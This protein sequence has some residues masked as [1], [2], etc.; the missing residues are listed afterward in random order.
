MHWD[1]EKLRDNRDLALK[2]SHLTGHRRDIGRL[3][4]G[5]VVAT[6]RSDLNGEAYLEHKGIMYD[7]TPIA[8]TSYLPTV[9]MIAQNLGNCCALVT[10]RMD[11]DDLN[12]IEVYRNI[13]TRSSPKEV[14]AARGAARDDSSHFLTS[15]NDD[16]YMLL[17][18]QMERGASGS[19]ATGDRSS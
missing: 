14:I 12:I 18:E 6:W 3:S 5:R 17:Y 16:D 7:N 4:V 11:I 2:A 10:F 15:P 8:V 19:Y 1:F 13:I 9:L